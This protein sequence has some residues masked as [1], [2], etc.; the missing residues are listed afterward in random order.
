MTRI[1]GGVKFLAA[2]MALYAVT[3]FVDREFF[4]AI[5]LDVLSSIWKIIPILLLAYTLMFIMNIFIR[6]D[7]IGRHLGK[8]SGLKGW[9]YV[10]LAGIF[11]PSPPYVVF[12]MLGEFRKRGMKDSLIAAFLYSRNLQVAFIPVMAY[13]FGIAF[14]CVILAYVFVFSILNGIVMGK[15]SQR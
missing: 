9:L 2:M 7:S 8:D 10:M 12:P 1:N 14:T 5:S 15:L 3:F 11:I 6:P 4:S 13:Y